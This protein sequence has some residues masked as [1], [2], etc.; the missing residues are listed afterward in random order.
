MMI[1]YKKFILLPL[2][3]FIGCANHGVVNAVPQQ[4][5]SSKAQIKKLMTESSTARA[6]HKAQTR[7]A[8]FK[9]SPY[10]P[11]NLLLNLD[12][13]IEE[14]KTIKTKKKSQDFLMVKTPA[15]QTTGVNIMYEGGNKKNR[16]AR[17]TTDPV[18]KDNKV[19][20]YWL[21]DARVQGMH[22]GKRKGRIQINLAE[23]NKTSVFQRYRIYLHPD[24]SKYRQYPN[25]NG[26]F[27]INEFMMGAHWKHHPYPFRISLNISKSAG[28]GKP[29]YFVASAGKAVS[30]GTKSNSK[31]KDIWGVVGYKFEVPVG[32]W[33]DIEIG[34]KQGN[35]KTGR[36]YLAAKREKDKKFT[37]VFDI[38]DWT[39]HPNSPKPVALTHW[40]PLKIYT[41]ENIINFVRNKGGVVQ[42]YF[43]DVELYDNW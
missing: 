11:S 18:A 24:L 3:L 6:T 14:V 12:F 37:T 16:Y 28:V 43:D 31:W 17:V 4:Q 13:E 29:L 23:I 39:Y 34:Y 40:Y 33:I 9:Q 41:G 42:M 1:S 32:E 8:V 7:D 19:L 22:K 30:G 5:L 15:G 38:R 36:F 27:T 10:K 2:L 20:Q 26:W 21:K 35:K 25:G